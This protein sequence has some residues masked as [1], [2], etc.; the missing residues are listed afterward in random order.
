VFAGKEGSSFDPQENFPPTKKEWTK[1]RP[2]S[3]DGSGTDHK[4]KKERTGGGWG[5]FGSGK[6]KGTSSE[7]TV[8]KSTK[9]QTGE[10]RSEQVS[11]QAKK[12]KKHGSKNTVSQGGLKKKKT[13]TG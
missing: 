3:G 6:K 7:E 11:F 5:S 8:F 12:K 13:E 9:E 2:K 4:K 1:T 10:L